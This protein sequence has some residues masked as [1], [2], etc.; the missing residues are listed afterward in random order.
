MK[1]HLSFAFEIGYY[2]DKNLDLTV[3]VD[4]KEIKSFQSLSNNDLCVILEP[5]LPCVIDFQISGK[6]TDH[7]VIDHQGNII[8][9]TYIELKTMTLHDLDS[10]VIDAW[11]I[12]DAILAFHDDSLNQGPKT[13][14]S[15]DGTA[16]LTL[17][18]D[19]IVIWFLKHKSLVFNSRPAIDC[20]DQ[21]C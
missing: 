12:P 7:R 10:I 1:S 11:F 13:F 6:K 15:Q 21:I 5:N 20:N 3:Q 18:E 9:D 16:R 14:W 17:D 2:D 4:G 8:K 19:D